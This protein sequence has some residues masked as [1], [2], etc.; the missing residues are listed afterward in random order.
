MANTLTLQAL[1][2]LFIG[3]NLTSQL[4]FPATSFSVAGSTFEL[5]QF[6]VPTTAGG[7]ALPLGGVATAGG[8]LM[9]VNSDATNYVQLMTAASGTVFARLK[10]GE[11][12][13]LRLDATITAVA[14]IA[15]TAPCLVQFLLL[16]P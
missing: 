3:S 12:A 8:F 14:A 11:C 2:Q 4:N 16:A 13:V 9:I 7:T 10:P 6:S 1:L 5:T 15:N